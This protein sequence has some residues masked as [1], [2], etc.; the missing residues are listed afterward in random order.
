MQWNGIY[1]I[2]FQ[3][4]FIFQ[5]YIASKNIIHRDLAAGNILLT[6]DKIAKVGPKIFFFLI[7]FC[8]ISDFG[9][10][11]RANTDHNFDGQNR[12]LL[13]IR[14]SAPETFGFRS[15]SEKSDMYDQCLVLYKK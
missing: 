5:S 4:G 12:K 7:S 15:F 13:P 6:E 8:Q 1:F 11:I 14:W 3:N 10:S 2:V 9:M